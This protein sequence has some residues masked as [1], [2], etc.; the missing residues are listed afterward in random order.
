M[1]QGPDLG[2][3]KYDETLIRPTQ[4]PTATRIG[5]CHLKRIAGARLNNSKGRNT[6]SYRELNRCVIR[7]VLA[8][9][10]R[11]W[12]DAERLWGTT[13]RVLQRLHRAVRMH[14]T[15][16]RAALQAIPDVDWTMSFRGI[17]P[18][19]VNLRRNRSYW[20][21]D[22]LHHEAFMLGAMHRLISPGDT[23][24]DVGANIGLYSRLFIQRFNCKNVIAFEPATQN[25]ALLHLN[26]RL[27]NCRDRITVVATALADYDGTDEFQTDD[28][29][30]ATG[31][32]NVV[33][34]GLPSEARRQYGLPPRTEAV[35]VARLDT[36]M[37]ETGA[38]PIPNVIKI[39]IEGAEERMLRGATRTLEKH[40]PKLA[41]ELHG[42]DASRGV[43]SFLLHHGYSVFG[44]LNTNRGIVY[45]EIV[46]SDI[47]KFTN[48]Y[49]LHFCIAARNAE[50]LRTPIALE[51]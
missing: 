11:H 27:G 43:V 36:M 40:S 38:V 2:P 9:A 16:G 50:L 25:L 12:G 29:S 10:L 39:D 37:V 44:Y 45:K 51:L 35:T 46:M 20:L 6:K 3:N 32:L 41:I 8:S 4:A 19:K 48:P 13:V 5:R 18:M 17:G 34:R 49:S 31:T 15:L 24:F 7:I 1:P 28:V 42:I 26:I 33:T 23:V 22:P 21:R 47:G 30:T 14:P